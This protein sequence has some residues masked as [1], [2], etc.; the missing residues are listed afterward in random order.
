L[1]AAELGQLGF[2]RSTL[3]Q[4]LGRKHRFYLV[5]QRDKL[6]DA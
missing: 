4:H 1:K 2:E 5:L 3:F 6:L